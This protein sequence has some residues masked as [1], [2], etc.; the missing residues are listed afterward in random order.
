MMASLIC[1]IV[2]FCVFVYLEVVVVRGVARRFL[3]LYSP[4]SRPVS[5]TLTLLYFCI[6]IFGKSIFMR[7]PIC[8]YAKFL[9]C[10]VNSTSPQYIFIGAVFAFSGPKIQ[11]L[12]NICTFLCSSFPGCPD[13]KLQNY[14]QVRAGK[15]LSKD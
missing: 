8:K 14:F 11:F 15:Q 1:I 9:F 6:S 2:L 13:S 3:F 4:P 12:C 7:F 5:P 10:R